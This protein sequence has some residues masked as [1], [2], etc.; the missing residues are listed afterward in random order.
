VVVKK[1]TGPKIS[2]VR[3]FP[4]LSSKRQTLSSSHH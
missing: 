2:L 4:K 3:V 1:M